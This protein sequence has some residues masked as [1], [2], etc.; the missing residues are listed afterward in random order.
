MPVKIKIQL[1]FHMQ[2]IVYRPA[3]TA[4]NFAMRLAKRLALSLL[5]L[6]SVAAAADVA[7]M[8]GVWKLNLKKS[9][10]QGNKAPLSVE[11]RI[12]HNDPALKYSGT[13]QRDQEA[14]P[15]TF[16]FD[17]AI[18]EKI[19][20]V[21]ENHHTGRTIKFKRQSPRSVE[22]WSSDDTMEEH[23]V[24]TVSGKTLIRKMHVKQKDG[25]VGDWTEFYD[26][27]S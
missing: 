26:K 27:Q 13:I 2:R 10:F 16:E 17:G 21:K 4:S 7:N 8:T 12:Q 6:G 24:T 11:L 20:P 18:D 19:Y 1:H 23:A 22:S 9:K 5:L 3:D 15:D 14:S 25:K